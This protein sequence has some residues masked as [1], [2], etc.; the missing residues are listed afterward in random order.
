MKKEKS[1]LFGRFIKRGTCRTVLLIG[2]F[3][4]KAVPVFRLLRGLICKIVRSK[5][6]NREETGQII[7]WFKEEFAEVIISGC[8]VNLS[9]WYVSI[10]CPILHAK[11]D[12]GYNRGFKIAKTY[13]SIFGLINIQRRIYGS[14]PEYEQIMDALRSTGTKWQTKPG[15]LMGLVGSHSFDECNWLH[16]P[17]SSTITLIDYGDVPKTGQLFCVSY[18]VCSTESA[19]RRRLE[20]EVCS[21]ITT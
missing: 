15:V 16:E 17:S 14:H 9:E 7:H 4:I 20:S 21:E 13:F 3:A 18:V 10:R 8:I 6:R 11:A 2:P 19:L 5:C 12:D 1:P